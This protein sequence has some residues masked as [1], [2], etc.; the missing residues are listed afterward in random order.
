M[1]SLSIFKV[2][3]NFSKIIKCQDLTT[4]QSFYKNMFIRTLG[5]DQVKTEN[6]IKSIATLSYLIIGAME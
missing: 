3:F 2:I 6:K 5:W 1:N 4:L